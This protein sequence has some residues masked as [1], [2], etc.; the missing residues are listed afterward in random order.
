MPVSTLFQSLHPLAQSSP[1]TTGGLRLLKK[2][3]SCPLGDEPKHSLRLELAWDLGPEDPADLAAS[4]LLYNSQGE[5]VEHVDAARTSAT[6]LQGI[7]MVRYSGSAVDKER[8]EARRILNIESHAFPSEVGSMYFVISTTTGNLGGLRTPRMHLYDAV[9]N[10][11]L[12]RSHPFE[13]AGGEKKSALIMCKVSRSGAK[14]QKPGWS[15]TVVGAPAN[16]NMKHYA[17]I[18]AKI[19]GKHKI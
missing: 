7:P 13:N 9:S 17:M 16:G 3:D 4:C 15:L 8:N 1:G 18:Q 10:T 11:E 14:S 12:C 19:Q 6:G 2:G 5:C